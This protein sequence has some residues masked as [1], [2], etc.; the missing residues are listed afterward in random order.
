MLLL[1]IFEMGVL[2]FYDQALQSAT[3]AAGRLLMTGTAQQGGYT[4]QQ[5]QQAVCNAAGSAFN[6]QKL[7]VDVQSAQ[8]FSSLNTS[9]I[10]LN[11]NSSGNVTNSFNY[12]PGAQTNAVIV[13]VMYDFPVWWP[14]LL[15][16]F[17]NQ[18]GQGFLL[19]GTSVIRNEPYP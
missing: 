9:P 15:P 5:F 12:S 18:Q 2:S 13:R 19:I 17:A 7:Y 8:N 10:T 11:Y 6:C 4:Q 3:E 14:Q 16:R 1:G